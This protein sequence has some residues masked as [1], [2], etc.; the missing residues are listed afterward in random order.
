MTNPTEQQ[1]DQFVRQNV[2]LCLSSLVSTLAR[3]LRGVADASQ[4]LDTLAERA[5]DL[6]YPVEDYEE[7]ARGADYV[8]VPIAGT[9]MW[10][11]KKD[12]D[13]PDPQ[14]RR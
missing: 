8:Q 10:V 14:A 1:L 3:G 7:A 6:C 9:L 2:H 4:D 5:I 12:K 11:G 13:N